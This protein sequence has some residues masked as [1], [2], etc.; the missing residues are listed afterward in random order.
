MDIFANGHLVRGHWLGQVN[1]ESEVFGKKCN[2]PF[3]NHSWISDGARIIDPTRFA[4]EAKRPYIWVGDVDDSDYDAGGNKFREVM[5]SPPPEYNPQE[6]KR[7]L[8]LDYETREFVHSLLNGHD[9]EKYSEQQIFW[10]ANLPLTHLGKYVFEIY[11]AII[12]AGRAAYIPLDNRSLV[13]EEGTT[14]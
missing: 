3:Q 7:K 9:K 13:V 4:F 14:C 11:H 1:P 8:D 10:L 12:K 6:K 5:M 2:L